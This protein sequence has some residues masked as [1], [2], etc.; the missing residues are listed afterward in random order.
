MIAGVRNRIS[1][2]REEGIDD[3]LIEILAEH[4]SEEEKQIPSSFSDLKESQEEAPVQVSQHG[5]RR[6]D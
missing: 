6:I 4:I 2:L 5:L 1:K 3:E